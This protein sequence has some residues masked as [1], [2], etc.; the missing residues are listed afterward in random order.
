MHALDGDHREASEKSNPEK[1]VQRRLDPT[2]L[3]PVAAEAP[4]DDRAD[5]A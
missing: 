4:D 2:N 1:H 5:A 3:W